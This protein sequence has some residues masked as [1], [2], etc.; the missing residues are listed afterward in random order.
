MAL[1][2]LINVKKEILPSILTLT[3]VCFAR[4]TQNPLN[5]STQPVATL[6]FPGSACNTKKSLPKRMVHAI[7]NFLLQL[8]MTTKF[9]VLS[10]N[11]LTATLWNIWLE[12][13]RRAFQGI[14]KNQN[15]L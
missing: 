10:N 15:G 12:R 8:K 14:S 13:N 9:Q 2:P 1:T 4:T 11:L 3:G 6:L 5:T 7:L